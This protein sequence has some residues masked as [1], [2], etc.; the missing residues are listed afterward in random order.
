MLDSSNIIHRLD[1]LNA[2]K[3]L[4]PPVNLNLNILDFSCHSVTVYQQ[5]QSSNTNAFVMCRNKTSE[6]FW[7][8]VVLNVL[9]AQ[10]TVT[11]PGVVDQVLY[12]N[13]NQILMY[14]DFLYVL[15]APV[16]PSEGKPGI[17][18]VYK[19]DW[20]VDNKFKAPMIT[21]F[22]PG[23]FGIH[24][25]FSVSSF[26]VEKTD[27][28]MIA[29]LFLLD[30]FGTGIIYATFNPAFT[31]NEEE[32]VYDSTIFELIGILRDVEKVFLPLNTK[33]M[34]IVQATPVQIT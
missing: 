9:S 2:F 30:A 29:Q 28:N 21:A 33:Y 24:S 22:R 8:L 18:Y 32:F 34:S 3:E 14:Q 6:E 10:A 31:G 26:V 27:S 15:N 20:S 4:T 12:S 11:L 7:G 25:E 16:F 23:V 1:A 5:W 13:P 17:L 19:P